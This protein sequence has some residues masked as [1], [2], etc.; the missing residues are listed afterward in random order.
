MVTTAP[1]GLVYI[2]TESG[3]FNAKYIP[4][5]VVDI[6]VDPIPYDTEQVGDVTIQTERVSHLGQCPIDDLNNRCRVGRQFPDHG[7]VEMELHDIV[8]GQSRIPRMA[9][10]ITEGNQQQD[11]RRPSFHSKV[12]LR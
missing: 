9:Y 3:E 4:K 2:L 7:Q 5:Y 6:E 1:E 12:K 10:D 8:Q 11:D